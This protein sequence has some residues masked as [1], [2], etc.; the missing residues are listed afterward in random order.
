LGIARPLGR[1]ALQALIDRL[2]SLEIGAAR[3]EGGLS[4]VP[5]L[6][7]NADED[8]LLLT[9][10]VLQ[11]LAHIEELHESGR[12]N[13]IRIVNLCDRPIV[14]LDGEELKGSKQN[15]I[16]NTSI[17]IGPHQS[18]EVPVSCVES[19]RWRWKS[20]RFSTTGRF[21]PSDMRKK[22]MARVSTALCT[23]GEYD[24]DQRAVWED[25]STLLVEQRVASNTSC[26]SDALD[27]IETTMVSE[28]QA[29]P[30]N[31]G[32]LKP[33]GG[34]LGQALFIGER[35]ISVELFGSD[36]L[37]TAAWPHLESALRTEQALDPSVP[38]STPN[39]DAL[40]R[41][42]RRLLQDAARAPLDTHIAPGGSS[43]SVRLT[44]EQAIGAALLRE[45]DVLHCT[46]YTSEER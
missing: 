13:R 1:S 33:R 21:M 30:V 32:A 23:S 22:K 45:K 44:S 27:A 25:T 37:C 19:G 10:A 26:M 7:A 17:R 43:L 14:A 9:E 34:E 8:A 16:L 12:V 41:Q 36:R 3:Q 11:G 18:V 29:A 24:A 2:S 6:G 15:R 35:L 20:R 31:L 38:S 39:A 40:E 46:V 4:V 28:N 42:V 5:L